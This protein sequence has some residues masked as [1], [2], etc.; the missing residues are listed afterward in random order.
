MSDLPTLVGI[1]AT[2]SLPAITGSMMSF[3]KGREAS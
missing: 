3:C 2:L 1:S